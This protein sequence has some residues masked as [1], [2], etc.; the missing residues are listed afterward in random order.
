M[1]MHDQRTEH[2][3]I[4]AHTRKRL[5]RNVRVEA[6]TG[7][8]GSGIP[9]QWRPGVTKD[10]PA[11]QCEKQDGNGARRS[12]RPGRRK[13]N[14]IPAPLQEAGQKISQHCKCG[15]FISVAQFPNPTVRFGGCGERQE[16]GSGSQGA[17]AQ[18]CRYV[19]NYDLSAR[20]KERRGRGDSGE[21][22][23]RPTAGQGTGSGPSPTHRELR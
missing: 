2:S 8:K 7:E 14:I 18:I 17:I 21:Q 16:F 1:H 15:L 13:S 5:R 3:I 6:R 11:E 10:L 20:R 12:R 23:I 19:C 4:P 22:A 9:P